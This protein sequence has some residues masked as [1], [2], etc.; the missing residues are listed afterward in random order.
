MNH[1][2]TYKTIEK[3]TKM[4]KDQPNSKVVKDILG[5]PPTSEPDSDI[6][7]GIDETIKVYGL[8][9]GPK[10]PEGEPPELEVTDEDELP[11]LELTGEEEL[12]RP[13]K[14]DEDEDHEEEEN[15]D[16][17]DNGD[18]KD[19]GKRDDNAGNEQNGDNTEEG[20]DNPPGEDGGDAEEGKD[21]NEEKKD[22]PPNEG[23][24]DG[25]ID[26]LDLGESD[27]EESGSSKD[28]GCNGD[29]LDGDDE[30]IDS[31]MESYPY[32]C[33]TAYLSTMNKQMLLNSR[34]RLV[35]DSWK[36]PHFVHVPDDCMWC[37]SHGHKTGECK[38]YVKWAKE[39]SKTIRQTKF[40]PMLKLPSQAKPRPYPP[41]NELWLQCALI[42]NYPRDSLYPWQL[43][44]QLEDGEYV[45]ARGVK[46]VA[47]NNRI[48]NIAPA[49][50]LTPSDPVAFLPEPAEFLT[51]TKLSDVATNIYDYTEQVMGHLR[52]EFDSLKKDLQSSV[53]TTM[54]EIRH[55]MDNIERS[56][57]NGRQFLYKEL[58]GAAD[59]MEENQ[60]AAKEAKNFIGDIKKKQKQ[61]A[62]KFHELMTK[63][64]KTMNE[65]RAE[66]ND[67]HVQQ[68]RN[69]LLKDSLNEL[70]L[71][72]KKEKRDQVPLTPV[73][74]SN[75]RFEEYYRRL[76]RDSDPMEDTMV[77]WTPDMKEVFEDSPKW[78]LMN[79]HLNTICDM[80]RN[81]MDPD[82]YSDKGRRF[83]VWNDEAADE[84]EHL[85]QLCKTILLQMIK[86]SRVV[87]NKRQP[88]R[89]E[90]EMFFFEQFA[91]NTA[92]QIQTLAITPDQ[93][94]NYIQQLLYIQQC[95]VPH[96]G[97]CQ[98]TLHDLQVA[99][100][101]Q[102]LGDNR[103]IDEFT[104]K[105]QYHIPGIGENATKHLRDHMEDYR[106]Q[107]CTCKLHSTT[108]IQ[109]PF[110]WTMKPQ[111]SYQRIEKE[112]KE[113][114]PSMS[115]SALDAQFVKT[116]IG[117]II[118]KVYMF[119]GLF[120]PRTILHEN[121]QCRK[122]DATFSE[123]EE[124]FLI[125]MMKVGR[126][127]KWTY[128]M[129]ESGLNYLRE[130][131]FKYCPC[132]YH[133]AARIQILKQ[134]LVNVGKQELLAYI[135]YVNSS[136]LMDWMQ[137]EFDYFTKPAH[138]ILKDL[139]RLGDIDQKKKDEARK[140]NP[141][142]AEV[143]YGGKP[144]FPGKQSY[145]DY[146]IY[147]RGYM[148]QSLNKEKQ[149]IPATT[150]MTD[151][152][153]P[154]STSLVPNVVATAE[155]PMADK[156]LV[157]EKKPMNIRTWIYH[158]Q[159]EDDGDWKLIP[160][161]LQGNPIPADQPP[162][163]TGIM[164]PDH[165]TPSGAAMIAETT[166]RVIKTLE[167]RRAQEDTAR[168]ASRS[169]GHS[170]NAMVNGP[171]VLYRKRCKLNTMANKDTTE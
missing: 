109:G 151:V 91:E 55:M 170:P 68:H 75:I 7:I 150:P 140:R 54:E 127:K 107:N 24:E 164:A 27:D 123:E 16:N 83:A 60:K 30:S 9:V 141:T 146:G 100:M 53:E 119:Y 58:K 41:L 147:R 90:Q 81:K 124:K 114:N 169:V 32:L 61:D 104:E 97:L 142:P 28:S 17:V 52:S 171:Y 56:T 3:P 93:M 154:T 72:I 33:T 160:V 80:N 42:P 105:L 128:D 2:D 62:K 111:P 139:K 15:D 34:C 113:I 38:W 23:K 31:D 43:Y 120:Y 155:I 19:D 116:M 125:N 73:Q 122:S 51:L 66:T 44:C 103:H 163:T 168:T 84:I 121:D 133:D 64:E 134:S 166:K 92:Y 35:P 6:E 85:A 5:S 110:P 76:E 82:D 25:E 129:L 157:S 36:P 138:A 78:F 77:R 70:A 89:D 118:A 102:C 21:D 63:Y 167:K 37:G 117:I 137:R 69:S 87:L 46:L 132:E 86:R 79:A 39:S 98:F 149:Q 95:E 159:K 153:P 50:L 152:A 115:R 106:N 11:D 12:K 29:E 145:R 4:T 96:S 130:I 99:A 45:T 156:P 158:A 26:T 94:Y 20:E 143:L 65:V 14:D 126:E 74:E 18:E 148:I 161:D 131:K 13:N 71:L 67:L 22:D 57:A 10:T 101:V 162:L 88:N 112:L 144:R 135:P 136:S 108:P 1:K 8:K 59:I 48:L 40:Q 49:H 165:S 47:K